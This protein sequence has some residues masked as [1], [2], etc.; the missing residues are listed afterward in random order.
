MEKGFLTITAEGC[1]A[2]GCLPGL[3]NGDVICAQGTG[4][5]TGTEPESN[6]N[7]DL[8]ITS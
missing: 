4:T 3:T 1:R 5:G 2:H 6:C 7:Y 8:D